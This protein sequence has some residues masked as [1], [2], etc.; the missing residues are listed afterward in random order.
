[1]FAAYGL[2]KPAALNGPQFLA[3][4][5]LRQPLS[6]RGDQASARTGPG[7]GVEI[8]EE[9]VRQLMPRTS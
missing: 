7:L 1:L 6:I 3:G 2:A 9:K 4:D 8:D 5:I